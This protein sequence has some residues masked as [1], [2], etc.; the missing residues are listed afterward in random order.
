MNLQSI[1]KLILPK[2]IFRINII[3]IITPAAFSVEIYK[4]ILHFI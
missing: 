2:F 4:M 3:P 1:V